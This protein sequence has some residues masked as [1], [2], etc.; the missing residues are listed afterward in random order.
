MGKQPK[1]PPIAAARPFDSPEWSFLMACAWVAF[2]TRAAVEAAAGGEITIRR[3]AVE[4]LLRELRAGR[5]T[6]WG[7]VDVST[8]CRKAKRSRYERQRNACGRGRPD[9]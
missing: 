7:R 8:G 2:R 3:A 1:Q 5:L 4:R 6:A 9:P